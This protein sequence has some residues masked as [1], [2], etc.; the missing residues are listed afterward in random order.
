MSL[1]WPSQETFNTKKTNN[2]QGSKTTKEYYPT[3]QK[4]YFP[5]EGENDSK[6]SKDTHMRV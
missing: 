4:R 2:N 3:I 5:Y 1:K 6:N